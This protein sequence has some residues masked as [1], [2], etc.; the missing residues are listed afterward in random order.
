MNLVNWILS[1]IENRQ[2]KTAAK[3]LEVDPSNSKRKL[4]NL[5]TKAKEIE[6]LAKE[7]NCE[8]EIKLKEE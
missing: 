4:R 3:V 6:T 7:M 2:H 8:I 5:A 1:I